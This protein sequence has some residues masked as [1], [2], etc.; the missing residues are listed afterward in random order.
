MFERGISEEDVK[1]VLLVG[2]E[3]ATYPD[4]HPY[5]S[6]LMLGWRGDRPIH[7]IVADN[8]QDDEQIVITVYEPD[9]VIWDFG[10]KRRRQ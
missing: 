6:R 9:P 1:D 7:V 3:I 4:D 10:F 8:L 2:E 5:P